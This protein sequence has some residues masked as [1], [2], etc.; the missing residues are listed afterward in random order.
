MFLTET[1][2]LRLSPTERT[3][4]VNYEDGTI[5]TDGKTYNY[6]EYV[7]GGAAD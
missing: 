7:E 3:V 1:S 5:E 2:Q 4:T 6:S